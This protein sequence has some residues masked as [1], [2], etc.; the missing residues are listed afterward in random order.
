MNENNITRFEVSNFKKFDHLVVEN[1]GQVNLITGDN[2][3]GKTTL[4]E[5]LLFSDDNRR[6]IKYLHQT[7]FYRGI[8]INASNLNSNEI[9]FPNENYLSYI[10]KDINKR[11]TCR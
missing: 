9:A 10:F 1:I 5:A 8:H 4:L 7:L 6:W 11:L 2:N 3:V